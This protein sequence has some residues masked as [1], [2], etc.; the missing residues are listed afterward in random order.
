VSA[1]QHAMHLFFRDR[2]AF[3]AEYQNDP[4]A[5]SPAAALALD[6]DQVAAKATN[7][8]RGAVPRSATRLVA[9]VDVGHH[10]LWYGVAAWDERFGGCLVDAGCFPD[11]ARSYF[12]K[13]DVRP[14]L[15]DLPEYQ[16][17]PLEAVVYAALGVVADRVLGR[18]YRQEGTGAELR[19]ERCPV[20]ANDGRVTDVVY[21]FCRRSPH[22]AVLLPSHGKFVGATS[23]PMG[24]WQR[25]EGERVGW[26]WRVSPPSAGRGRHLVFDANHWK[27]FAAERLRTPAA[28][29]GCL[30]LFAA[31]DRMRMLAD[32]LTSEYPVAATS[33]GRT[34]EEWKDRPA[35]DNDWWDVLVGCCVAA[36]LQGLTWSSAAAAGENGPGPAA[37]RKVDIEALHKK[38]RGAA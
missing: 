31:G 36:S 2:R 14:A 32:H 22:A 30:S 4:L 15:E 12:A 8:P 38:A 24:T 5:D 35:R 10:V 6:P 34:V 11:Q 3:F 1:V 9:F 13:A 21:E 19:V 25:K 29:P 17:K 37:R 20:D 26:G 33:R 16:G 27:S 28:A 18:A 23:N 7:L